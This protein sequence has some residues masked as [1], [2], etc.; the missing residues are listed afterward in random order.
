MKRGNPFV[1]TFFAAG[2]LYTGTVAGLVPCCTPSKG[3]TWVRKPGVTS[4][5]RKPSHFAVCQSYSICEASFR[6]ANCF[7]INSSYEIEGKSQAELKIWQV[8]HQTAESRR[9]LAFYQPG[10]PLPSPCLEMLLPFSETAVPPLTTRWLHHPRSPLRIGSFSFRK[11]S[12]GL[13]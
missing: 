1:C 6:T 11:A 12:A 7:L 8:H 5:W 9:H 2:S 13:L 4:L 3:H 10:S